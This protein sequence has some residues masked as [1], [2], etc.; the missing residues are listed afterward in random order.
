MIQA[1]ELRIGSWVSL[2]LNHSD[3]SEFQIELADLNLIATDKNRNYN[4]IP[5]TEEW[6]TKFGFEQYT[7][8]GVK[9]NTFDLMP[10]CGFAYD[11]DTKQVII[12][13]KRNSMSHWIERKIE[14][15]H[16]LQNLYFALRGQ[17]LTIKN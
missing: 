13:E 4:P 17:E 6:L 9:F 5:I 1:N 11:T 14:Y 3:T 8:F 10:L 7:D 12:Q 2:D 16:E 15:V